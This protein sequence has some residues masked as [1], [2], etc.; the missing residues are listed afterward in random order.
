MAVL[1]LDP[2]Q[3]FFDNDGNPLALGL[4]YTY[5]AVT[6]DPRATFT[7]TA[8]ATEHENPIV[9]D[10]SGRPPSPIFYTCGA[11]YNLVLQNA[12][13]VVQQSNISFEIPELTAPEAS[14]YVDVVVFR[15]GAD[16]T[17]DEII[18]AEMFTHAVAF[19]ANWTGSYAVTTTVMTA[20]A[21]SYVVTVKKN[22]STCGTI[23]Y[24]ITT[25]AATFATSAGAAVSFAAG[26]LISFHGQTVPDAS[27][28]NFGWTLAGSLA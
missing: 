24:A 15:A 26:D 23:T 19:G 3:Q 14:Q 17:A 5:D 20:P 27:I 22:G 28:A 8:G 16:T 13:E 10:S 6:S 4:V 18:Y 9:L 25:G 1:C 11:G 7:D 2:L 21:A 12:A